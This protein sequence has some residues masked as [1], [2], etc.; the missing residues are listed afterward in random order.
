MFDTRTFASHSLPTRATASLA[1]PARNVV[2]TRPH[3]Y[4][5]K[6]H[7]T[8]TLEMHRMRP[9]GPFSDGLLAL[10][11]R[12]TSLERPTRPCLQRGPHTRELR[13]TLR[14]R[15]PQQSEPTCTSDG[16]GGPLTPR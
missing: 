14:A 1:R 13:H 5:Q 9:T 6:L 7:M 3:A 11:T 16:G 15:R 12:R 8:R 2:C 10:S 4:T